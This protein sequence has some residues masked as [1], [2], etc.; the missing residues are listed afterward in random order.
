MQ[1][2]PV[3]NG[4]YLEFVMHGAQKPHFWIERDGQIF[5]RG[6]FKDVPLPLD[7]PVYVTQLEAE[8]YAKW[9]GKSIATE[10]QYHRAAFGSEHRQ[11]PWGNAAPKFEH[12]NF[13]FKRW[14]PESAYSAGAGESGFGIRQLVGNG[15]EWTSTP[16][17]PFPGF[18]ARAS[19]PG[20][21]ANFFDGEHFVMKG[22]SART[23]ARLLRGSF[24]N[25]FR[26]DYPYMYSKF[27]CVEN[28]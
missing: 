23:A 20:Y 9:A 27:R 8:A 5:Y 14:D 17:A 19:Y 26:R 12:G 21:S 25:W 22:G 15:W 4:E 18:K 3:T 10:E 28:E 11:Y 7:S 16:F 24:R 6:M 13:D 2:F 1:R